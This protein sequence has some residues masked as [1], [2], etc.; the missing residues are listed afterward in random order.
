[1][2]RETVMALILLAEDE[3]KLRSIVALILEREG[4]VVEPAANGEEA[5]SLAL[6]QN[7][8]LLITDILMPEKDGLEL[9]VDLRHTNT[10]IKILAMSAGSRFDATHYL[11]KAHDSG[12]NLTLLKPFN[13]QEMLEAVNFLLPATE[14]VSLMEACEMGS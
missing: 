1:M 3:D 7:F 5:L 13:R 8:D 10:E 12:A 14:C 11:K 2:I 6:Q 9:I 4:H